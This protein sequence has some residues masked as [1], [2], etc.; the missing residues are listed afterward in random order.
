MRI[1]FD[2]V[3]G[4][5]NVNLGSASGTDV[6]STVAD[7]ITLTVSN[8]TLTT[9]QTINISAS[10][11]TSSSD[12]ITVAYAT[13]NGSQ[14]QNTSFSITGGAGNDTLRG[15]LNSDTISG[16][17]GADSIDGQG[18]ADQLTGG[19]GNDTFVVTGSTGTAR[20]TIVDFSSGD[21]L[22][23]AITPNGAVLDA[24]SKGSVTNAGDAAANFTGVRGQYVFNTANSTLL[25]DSD[26]SGFITA[27]DQQVVLSNVASFSGSALDFVITGSAATNETVTTGAGDDRFVFGNTL[28]AAD[29]ING[30]AGTDTLTFTDAGGGLTTDIDLVT[31]VEVITLDAAATAFNTVDANVSAGATLTING[32]AMAGNTTAISA[33]LE[34]DGNV[35]ISISSTTGTINLHG[36][37]GNDTLSATTT[38]NATAITL[39]GGAGND[40]LQVVSTTSAGATVSGTATLTGGTGVDTITGG[41]NADT[42][43]YLLQAHLVNNGAVIDS[44]N[45]GAGTD[46]LSI[47]TDGTAFTI[48]A[49][50]SFAR[51]T[52]VETITAVANSAAVSI[53]LGTTAET[54]GIR[55]VNLAAAN[56]SASHVINVSAFSSAAGTTLTGAATVGTAITG[57]AGA[58]TITGSTTD[59]AIDI[60][61]GGDGN[62]VFV[63]AESADLIPNSG[64]ADAVVDSVVGGAGT[65]TVSVSGPIS[66]GIAGADSLARI[67]TVER[68]VAATQSLA[69]Q[70]HVVALASNAAISDFRTID[71]SGDTGATS[72]ATVNV[73]GVTGNMTIVGVNGGGTNV[74]TGGSGADTITGGIGSDTLSGGGGV[75]SINGGAGAD[76]IEGGA[77]DDV[78][79]GGAG[80]DDYRITGLT[81]GADSITFSI[82]DGDQLL[83]D[84]DD[85]DASSNSDLF[86]LGGVVTL[87]NTDPTNVAGTIVALNNV[88]YNEAAGGALNFAT[89]KLNVITT[90]GYSG[91][92]AALQANGGSDGEKGI[93]VFFN[94]TTSRVEV[95]YI[96]D[97]DSGAEADHK[98]IAV[99]NGIALADVA[100]LSAANFGVYSLG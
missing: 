63:Y 30:G 26:G 60:L 54:A 89:N 70:T 98:L 61:S 96:S 86:D 2:N 7:S 44:V 90:T 12:S 11:I 55:S 56:T 28:T 42:I 31:N 71:L 73:T 50:D 46:V 88:D 3:T 74:L 15:A 17:S 81:V 47:G 51:M 85:N 27:T 22:Q 33:A 68:L 41:V 100:S 52:N 62:D 95:Y 75:D 77:G 10:A 72:G 20:D 6:S 78:L 84:V 19:A 64:A 58:D 23:I 24:T 29:L 1:D 21:R 83:F 53:T 66:I 93:L 13:P 91:V 76:L 65:D 32:T 14:L 35:S 59:A 82:S 97:A 34:T 5:E 92:V 38:T 16:G 37:A 48:A 57:G 36:G 8:L 40:T 9:T 99:L 67:T 69:N 39:T 87:A 4:V 25:V 94:T 79:I 45:G 18:G 49:S 80:A 43:V